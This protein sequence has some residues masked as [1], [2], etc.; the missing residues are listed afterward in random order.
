MMEDNKTAIDYIN[1]GGPIHARTRYIGVK[2]YF[3]KQ[4]IDAGDMVMVYCPT[5]EMIA[6]VMTKPVMGALFLTLRNELVFVV[7]K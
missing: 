6:D 1:Y 7:P 3:A 4:Y 5:E 2:F